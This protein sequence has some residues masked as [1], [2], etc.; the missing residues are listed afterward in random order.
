[1]RL[2]AGAWEHPQ[3]NAAKPASD[4]TAAV[5]EKKAKAPFAALRHRTVRKQS[6]AHLRHYAKKMPPSLLESGTDADGLDPAL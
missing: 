4:L 3:R 2:L 6:A 1:M 5:R